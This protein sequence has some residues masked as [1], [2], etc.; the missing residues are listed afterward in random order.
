MVRLCRKFLYLCKDAKNNLIQEGRVALV[1]Q[2]NV[3]IE[4][5]FQGNFREGDGKYSIVL[6]LETAKGIVT[7]EHYKGYRSTS[8]NRLAI[9]ACIEALE[10]ITKPCEVNIFL[11]SPYMET[12]SRWL[13]EWVKEGLEN[14]KNGDLWEKYRAVAEKHLVT[15]KNQKINSYTPAMKIQLGVKKIIMLTD[16]QPQNEI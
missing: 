3:Y 12:S 15:I 10:H 1:Q 14:R 9:L 11:N 6:E 4:Q 16:Y 8:K 2:V 13:N 5:S 7:R